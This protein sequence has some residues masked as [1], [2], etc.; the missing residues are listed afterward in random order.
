[1]K[2]K[3]S[4]EP[5]QKRSIATKNRIK[6]TAKKLFSEK[7]YYA[8]TSNSIAAKANVPIG[9]FYNYF[10]NKKTLLLELIDEFNDLYHSDTIDQF[11]KAVHLI[12]SKKT[13][14]DIMEMLIKVSISSPALNDS[15]Y[16]VLHTLQFT[17]SDVLDYS[18]KIRLTEIKIIIKFLKAIHKFHPQ[19]NIPLKAKL[20]HSTLENVILYQKILGT[21]FKEK[22]LISETKKMFYQYI[23]MEDNFSYN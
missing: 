16:K 2:K 12:T 21:T 1:M 18:E 13:A 10:G 19:K 5:K 20:L 15:F 22:Q 3:L 14:I 9:S 11:D 23:F 8:V 6:S 17:D 7:G 4:I